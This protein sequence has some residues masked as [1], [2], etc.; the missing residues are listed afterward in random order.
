MQ[1]RISAH[2]SYLEA[3]RSEIAKRKGWSNDPNQYQLIRIKLLAENVFEPIRKH[4]G[5]PIFIWSMFRTKQVN[6]ASGGAKNSQ[7]MANNA[8]AIDIDAQV[9]GVLTNKRIFDYIRKNIEFDQLIGEGITEDGD[10]DWIHISFN[11][12]KNRKQILVMVLVDGK[13]TYQKFKE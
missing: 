8:A 13:P 3:T 4:F 7:H 10:Y 6:E 9:F 2:I 12:G 11:E 1:E 5:L